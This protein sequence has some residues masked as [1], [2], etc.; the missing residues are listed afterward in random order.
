MSIME[1]DFTLSPL[2]L[3]AAALLIGVSLVGIE[4][5]STSWDAIA[6]AIHSLL[7]LGFVAA[8]LVNVLRGWRQDLVEAR[9]RLRAIIVVACGGYSM[10]VLVV[11][12]LLRA[13]RPS[14]ELLLLNAILL[15]A[16]LFGLA[17]SVLDVSP[18]V[19]S[20]FGWTDPLPA[21]LVEP[22]AV[23][24]RD[25]DE[26][27]I[28][29]LRQ[30]MTQNAL[31]RDT[32]IGIASVA[33]RLG[34]PEKKLREV[35]NGRLGFK[36]FPSYVNAFR[37]E[38]VRRRLMD[39]RQDDVPI[40]TMAL[41]AGFGSVVAFNRAFKER[42]GVTPSAYRAGRDARPDAARTAKQGEG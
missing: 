2:A 35:I 40:L 7:G 1:D 14:Q 22:A 4:A 38:E 20:A 10:A 39:P 15:A 30:L 41:E 28:E 8:A 16:L 33:T 25:R 6:V 12:L 32:G 19:R 5:R 11:E 24:S 29:K 18:S 17:C 13:S 21:P 23:R 36:N 42:A 37:V 26:E 31:Y 27:L 3:A 9:R 34:V